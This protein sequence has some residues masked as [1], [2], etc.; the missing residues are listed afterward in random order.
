MSIPETSIV[1]RAFNEE[2]HLPRLLDALES[3]TYR[4]FEI[5]VV[6]SGS[7]DGTLEIARR[8]N[9]HLLRVDNRDFTFGYSLNVGIEAAHG[10]FVIIVSAHTEPTDPGWAQ[11]LIAP[12]RSPAVAV[13]YGRQLG[14]PLSRFGEAQD[15]RR[16]FG[17]RRRAL[18]RPDLFANNANAAIRRELWEQHHFDEALPGLEDIAWARHWMARGY[19]IAYEPLAAV[20][21]IH[22]E[23]W[24]QVRRRYYREAMAARMI[25]TKS[26][27]NA[28]S[29]CAREFWHLCDDFAAAARSGCLL[30]RGLEVL[31]FRAHKTLGTVSGL[32]A[33]RSVISGQARDALYFDRRA[34]AVVIRGP[35][36]ASLEEI[37]LPAVKPGDVLIRVAYEGV[38][39][40]DLEI[41]SGSLGY[42]KNGMSSYPIVPGHEFSGWVAQ[43]GANVQHLREGDPVVVECIQSC[44]ECAQCA[45]GN[46]IACR[47]R[48][49]VGVMGRNGAYAES[50]VVPGRFVHKI[51]AGLDMRVAALCEPL[52]V[53]LKGT[54]RLARLLDENRPSL[55]YAAAMA[56]P[57]RAG[58]TTLLA[59]RPRSR[60]CA[61]VGGGPIGHLCAQILALEGHEVVVFDRDPR[62]RACFAGTAIQAT[63]DLRE[64]DRFEVLVEA[65]GDA[66]ALHAI[67]S[68]SAAGA[69]I[70]LL[71]LPYARREFNF[72]DIVAL[73]KTIVSSLG[74]SA[75]DFDEALALLPRL[76]V[77]PFLERI[78]PLASFA[79]A[80]DSFRRR[81]H[82]KVLLEIGDH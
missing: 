63:E 36:R 78:M 30:D 5:I 55:S 58:G 25:G 67:L 72:E 45:G 9:A 64:L 39:G 28:V 76:P 50:V 74:S 7:Y 10:R 69:M 57:P 42:F 34:K 3:Q 54:K 51:P 43:A 17:S 19:E 47:Q 24:R 48:T 15:L 46:W 6:D 18:T 27:A 32:F 79:D 41:V 21:H 31:A 4:D 52:A 77:Q 53:A 82:L 70:L 71:G 16:T 59:A 35:G 62:R 1:I 49:E 26:R 13:V 20:Y 8:R 2:R 40:T 60:R 61:V 12:L 73:D 29:E 66:E 65:T 11:A 80:W 81:E 44:G 75:E 68:N 37:E 14:V 56:Q 38:C 33:D 23:S 22:E